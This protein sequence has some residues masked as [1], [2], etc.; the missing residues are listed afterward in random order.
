MELV[1]T[2][3]KIL[4]SIEF[5]LEDFPDDLNQYIKIF[6]DK[7]TRLII[8]EYRILNR[9]Q[10]N[11]HV[12]LIHVEDEGPLTDSPKIP[13]QEN[14]VFR[15][16]IKVSERSFLNRTHLASYNLE[17]NIISLSNQ[18]NHAVGSEILLSRP[19]ISYNAANDYEPGYLA[20]SGGN[21][22]RAILSSNSGDSHPVTD[23]NFWRS[24]PDGTYVSQ[25][26]LQPRP[27][28][29]DLDTLMLIEILHSSTLPSAY[30]LLDGSSTC[31]EIN[32]KI[33]LFS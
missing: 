26:D 13:L 22:F 12:S 4:F 8:P 7:N 18:V 6:P 2:K 20:E 16:I 25:A 1:K 27:S 24:I 19:I 5:H 31:K 29:F 17:A 21:H 23:T 33:K 28:D 11:S 30:S 14:E 3:Y 9:K 32:Y 10:K 15:F